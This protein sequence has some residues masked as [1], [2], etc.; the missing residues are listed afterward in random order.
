VKHPCSDAI[1]DSSWDND[2]HSV[3]CI[4][5]SSA[6]TVTLGGGAQV[7]LD[8]RH[9]SS[10]KTGSHAFKALCPMTCV[11]DQVLGRSMVDDDMRLRPLRFSSLKAVA[12]ETCRKIL[13]H[14]RDA[15]A[16]GSIE[17]HE[18]TAV[19]EFGFR[20]SSY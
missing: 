17:A 2:N 19:I 6:W 1:D 9:A 3:W 14:A 18:V 13:Q 12:C 15:M 16:A 11:S 4:P 10:I 20:L 7:C 5:P 8:D